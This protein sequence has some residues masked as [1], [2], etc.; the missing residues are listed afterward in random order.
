MR[1]RTLWIVAA[2]VFGLAA[3]AASTPAVRSETLPPQNW[4]GETFIVDVWTFFCPQGGS[5]DIAADTLAAG[6]GTTSPLDLAFTVIFDVPPAWPEPGTGDDELSCSDTPVCGFQCPQAVYNCGGEGMYTI[7]VYTFGG[8]GC[9]E[10][11]GRYE[12]S[13]EV[14][15]GPNRTGAALPPN[16][17]ALGGQEP[18]PGFPWGFLQPGPAADDH[19][20]LWPG[21]PPPPPPS[22]A[23]SFGKSF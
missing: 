23:W 5:A 19:R 9:G 3:P 2:L 1:S 4:Y 14:F 7:L 21:P 13:V 10:S 20:F 12:L 17:V 11:T 6:E 18:R 22:P 16:A 15:E 8:S